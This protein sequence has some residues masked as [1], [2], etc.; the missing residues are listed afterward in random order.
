MENVELNFFNL[1]L[2]F[3]SDFFFFLF[4]CSRINCFY[5]VLIVT[6][7]FLFYA[8]MIL[9]PCIKVPNIKNEKFLFKLTA[10]HCF[11]QVNSI[12]FLFYH[13]NK[14]IYA[15]WHLLLFLVTSLLDPLKILNGFIRRHCFEIV[16]EMTQKP[17]RTNHYQYTYRCISSSS[18]IRICDS[19]ES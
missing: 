14:I 13:E 18:T 1:T 12:F 8:L 5:F 10:V 17:N 3:S 9:R 6:G 2:N 19:L 16:T 11:K 15:E 4:K 7:F